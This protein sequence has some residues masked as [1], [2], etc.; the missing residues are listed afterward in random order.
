MGARS[1]DGSARAGR[2]CKEIAGPGLR[3]KER[4]DH[5]ARFVRWVYSACGGLER[6][7]ALAACRL[8]CGLA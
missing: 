5:V 4:F 2:A 3:F 6:R 8:V 1:G 7:D